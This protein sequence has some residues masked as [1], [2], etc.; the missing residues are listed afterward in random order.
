MALYPPDDPYLLQL[1][2]FGFPLAVRWYGVF[3]MAGALLAANIATRRALARGYNPDHVWNQL[4]LGLLF[5]IAG[6]RLYYVFFEWERFEANWLSALNITTGGLAIHGGIIGA[7]LAA[8]VYTR[9]QRLPF[10]DW[11]DVCVPGFLLAQGIGRWGNFF[12]QEAYGRPTDLPI[13]VR[14]DDIHRLP[15]YTD[16]ERYPPST[17]FHATFLYESLWNAVGFVLLI[18]ADRRYGHGAPAE[19]RRLLPGDLFFL[20]AIYYSL[21]RFWIE[22]LRTDSLCVNGIGGECAGSLR[23]AQI[24]SIS[25]ILLGLLGLLVNHLRWTSYTRPSI[26][27]RKS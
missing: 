6:A 27:N 15:P 5:G 24:V 22:G 7:L 19:Q 8:L 3:I 14:I 4:M 21:G 13:G 2:L 18:V 26:A 17:L 11:L 23:A 1:T 20:Y 25:L 9:S 16:M 12:N 10:W